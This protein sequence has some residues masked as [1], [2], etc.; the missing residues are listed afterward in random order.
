MLDWLS[1]PKVRLALL[2]NG[3]YVISVVVPWA[4]TSGARRSAYAH[5]RSVDFVTT[6]RAPVYPS[7]PPPGG[8]MK[9]T[10]Y[11][12]GNDLTV[13]LEKDLTLSGA[14]GRRLLL[15]PTFTVRK[16]EETPNSVLLRFVSFSDEKL[17][18]N[19]ASFVLSA[20][21]RQVWPAQGDDGELVWESWK[22]EPVPPF[23]TIDEQGWV[24]ENVGKTIPYEVFADVIGAKR[25]VFNLGPHLVELNAEQLE[26]LRDMH[27]LI[28]RLPAQRRK[29]Q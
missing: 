24:V 6:A 29:H 17:F 5:R 28:A 2:V 3:L 7:L 23:A 21:G 18:S 25:V 16:D 19:G 27:R 22:E 14:R 20:D 1:N 4:H 10:R 9:A 11:D 26:A 8:P 13:Y 15:S 12:N